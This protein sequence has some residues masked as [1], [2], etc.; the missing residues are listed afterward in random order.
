MRGNNGKKPRPPVHEELRAVIDKHGATRHVFATDGA[1]Q[2]WIGETTEH[3]AQEG[4]LYFCAFKD[5]HFNRIVGYSIDSQMTSRLAVAA[6][7]NAVTRRG[8]VAG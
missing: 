3:R 8:G 7:N 1:N 5:V 6:L 4:N 2:L